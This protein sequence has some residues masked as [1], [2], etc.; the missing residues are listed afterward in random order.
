MLPAGH[1]L[2][3]RMMPP[4]ELKAFKFE[5]LPYWNVD[6]EKVVATTEAQAIETFSHL[7]ETSVNRRLRSDVPL[8]TSLSGGLDSSAIAA[9]ITKLLGSSTHQQASFSAIFPGFEKDESKQ[10]KIITQKLNLKNYS[11]T[12]TAAG[13]VNDFKK[14]QYHQEEPFQ[15]SSI[16]AQYKVYELA[17]EHGVTVLLDG[18]GADEILGGYHKYYHWYW[19]ELISNLRFKKQKSELRQAEQLGVNVEWNLKNYIS[20]FLPGQ[21]SEALTKKAINLQRSNPFITN[22]FSNT[23]TDTSSLEK[24]V[25]KKLND[26][27][28]YN[29]LQHGLQE[30]L[31]YADRNSMAHSREVRLPFLSHELVQ[32]VFSLQ[33]NYKIKNGFTKWILRKAMSSAL[34]N[35]IAWRKDKVGFEP[36]QQSWMQNKQ[37]Q[38][39]MYESKKKL[40]QHDILK[41]AVLDEPVNPQAAHDAANYD[42]RYLSAAECL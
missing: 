10:I 30:L 17:K 38:D 2:H 24:P 20:S 7:F 9:T 14:L 31:R 28:Y 13:L 32:F 12:P 29:T 27:L 4:G 39:Y 36:P 37:L 41:K 40:V 21:T 42:W 3:L 16:Y 8:G 22:D 15:S 19:Q 25:V 5:V 6:K 34:P 23:Y 26:I 18:Q 33:S 35:D 11:V 1:F